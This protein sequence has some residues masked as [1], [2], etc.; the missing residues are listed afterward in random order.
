[1]PFA[2]GQTRFLSIVHARVRDSVGKGAILDAYRLADE[3]LA[4]DLSYRITRLEAVNTVI[5][6]GVVYGAALL[7]DP[8]DAHGAAKQPARA[9]APQAAATI[10]HVS[11]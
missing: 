11:A 1:M 4:E 9:E 10:E 6:A 5:A 8:S 7:L 2:M 3:L